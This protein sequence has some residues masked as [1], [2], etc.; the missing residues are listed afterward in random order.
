MNKNTYETLTK[1]ENIESSC[2]RIDIERMS[3][4]LTSET[5]QVPSGLT[6]EETIQFILSHAK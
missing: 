6:R 5:I 2:V 3:K 1:Q 4:A